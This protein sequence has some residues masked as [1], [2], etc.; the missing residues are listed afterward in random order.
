MGFV[1]IQT[2]L[3]HCQNL[4]MGI[5]ARHFQGQTGMPAQTASQ[6]NTKPGLNRLKGPARADMDTFTASLASIPVN[7]RF[8]V[9]IRAVCQPDGLIRACLNTG[10]A[11]CAGCIAHPRNHCTDDADICDLG[12]GAGIGA[13]TQSDAEYVVVFDVVSQ[14]CFEKS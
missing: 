13:I 12:T 8:F 2:D 1:V 7:D 9:S 5:Q 11:A 10:V 6:Q 4:V 14:R 3:H